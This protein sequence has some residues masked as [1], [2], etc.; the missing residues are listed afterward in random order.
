[1][2]GTDV[3]RARKASGL[4]Q[5]QLANRL[6]V[7]QAYV[8]M[9]ERN[10][11][12]VPNRLA[13]KLLTVLGLPVSALP[14]GYAE[15]SLT[16]TQATSVLSRFGYP[17]FAYVRRHSP[18][19]PAEFLFRTL[20]AKNLDA[21]L[22]EALP[23]VVLTYPNLDWD[24]LVR[25]SKANDVQNRLGFVVT[26]AR[27]LAELHGDVQH[28]TKLS[29]WE[30]VLENSR[31]QR[32]DAFN[33]VTDAERRWLKTNRSPEAAHWNLLSNLS[34]SVLQQSY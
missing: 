13:R 29:T 3:R 4:R 12:T 2:S 7:S 28:A 16:S 22:V 33:D 26:V 19:N 23:W 27:N 1:M 24:W 14:V 21:R 6:G 32:E 30:K 17:G 5:N 20:L 31:L 18:L 9:L 15:T 25:E 34:A 10:R 8:S 11:R